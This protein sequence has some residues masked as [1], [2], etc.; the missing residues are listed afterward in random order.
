MQEEERREREREAEEEEEEA[1]K[2]EENGLWWERRDGEFGGC[3]RGTTN[4]QTGG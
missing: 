3:G 1:K 4:A 2:A